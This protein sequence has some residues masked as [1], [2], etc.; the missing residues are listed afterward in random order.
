MILSIVIQWK[1][2]SNPGKRKRQAR[3]N[4]KTAKLRVQ[5]NVSKKSDFVS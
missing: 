2:N 4:R 3:R 1:K 5:I